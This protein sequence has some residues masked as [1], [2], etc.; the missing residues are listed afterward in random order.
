MRIK[1]AQTCKENALMIRHNFNTIRDKKGER[2]K[3]RVN[4]HIQIKKAVGPK[5]LVHVWLILRR[6]R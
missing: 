5:G 3:G 2:S 6:L 1:L 4:G